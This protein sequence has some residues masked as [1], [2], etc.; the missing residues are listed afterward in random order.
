M[1]DLE[2]MGIEGINSID[3]EKHMKMYKLLGEYAKSTGNTWFIN[4]VLFHGRKRSVKDMILSIQNSNFL[5][6]IQ[7]RWIYLFRYTDFF[8]GYYDY[9]EKDKMLIKMFGSPAEVNHKLSNISDE[10]RI[11]AEDHSTISTILPF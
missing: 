1:K 6:S 4:Y 9:F 2:K 7:D 8:G 3:M 11:F 10:W 5:S